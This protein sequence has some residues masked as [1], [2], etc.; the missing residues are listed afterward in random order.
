MRRT[1]NCGELNEK[2][3]DK[4]V[5]LNGW[6][7]SSRDHGGLIFIDLRDR[8]GLTQIVFD[9]NVT[10]EGHSLAEKLRREDV[11]E[12]KGIV[13]LRGKG[14]ENP[15]LSTGK[16]EVFVD[17]V[18][19]LSKS[20]TPPIE[21]DDRIEV[22][23]D[24]KLKYRYL[25][26]RKPSLQ[27]NLAVRHRAIKIVRDVLD[28]EN[29]LEIETPILAKSTPEGARDYLVPSR[30]HPGKFYALPQSPQLFKQLLMVAGMDRYF[31]I[32]KCF[33]DEDLRADRQPEFT[34]VDVEM[35][36]ID[37]DD[38]IDV[39]ER[40]I[41]RLWDE[42]L[43]VKLKIPFKRIRYEEAMDKYGLDR[44]DLRFGLELKDITKVVE[45]SDFK[46][47]LDNVK[48]GGIVKALNLKG[49]GEKFSRKDIDELISFV[50][51]YGA[52]GLA[53][54]KYTDKLESN[55]VKFFKEDVQ[56]EII[57]ELDAE[58][59]DLLVFVSDKKRSIVNDALG[60]LRVNVAKKLGIIKDGF[61]FV[62]IVDFPLL[63]YDEDE[64]RYV[65]VHHPFTSPLK[66]DIRLLE[67]APEKVRSDAYD[68]VV[69]GIELGGG[70]IRIHQP[71]LQQR[72]FK[73]LGISDL[74]AQEKFGFLLDAFKYGA[75]PHGGIALG[76]D[77]MIAILTGNESIRDVI[78]FPKNKAAESLMDGAPSEV[79]ENQLRE[80]HVKVDFFRKKNVVFDKIIDALNKEKIDYEVMEHKAVYTSK[81]A[82][83]VR[84][85]ELRQGC[86]A[87]ICKTEKGFVQ[88]VVPGDK[89]INF[90]KL[91]KILDVKDIE[92]ANAGDVKK[93]SGCNIG[94]V[95]PLGNLFSI[96]VYFD[97]KVSENEIVAFNAGSH[98]RSIK[99]KFTDLKQ[100]TNAVIEDFSQ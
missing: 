13:K 28:N 38:I 94:S 21:I 54:M 8:Y 1:H 34:Q 77:R 32:A 98:M 23:E 72:V 79:D 11:V 26:L 100:L 93:V 25:D 49:C 27:K 66:E 89:E 63:A 46:V 78:A 41:A 48:A 9:P 57:K 92:L 43:G 6:V 5:V 69:N 75:P 16:I 52:K 36:F 95:P 84:G 62:W 71:E 58:E 24:I 68:I 33:R 53:W 82:A 65:S 85:T 88:A 29:F 15:N 22:N 12:V 39:I 4:K 61:E 44:P 40:M 80:L 74:E 99:M 31:Q 30:I 86:K 56:K 51:I 73:A 81:E 91:K 35:S 3:V 47:F 14:L 76:V 59:G 45:K 87:L 10:K 67:K 18:E 19:V 50:Q 55:I 37:R 70:S 90:D 20:E 97:K 2:N 17:E 7:H 64:Q 83:E 60:H 42:I 96:K